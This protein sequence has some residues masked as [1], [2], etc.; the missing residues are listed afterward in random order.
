MLKN[1]TK[2]AGLCMLPVAAIVLLI[3]MLIPAPLQRDHPRALPWELPDYRLANTHWEI[4]ADGRIYTEVEHFFLRDISP[5]MIAWF[6]Q[7]LPISTL[8]YQGVTYPLYH[9]FHP[10]EH[11]T[12][13][14]LE[15]AP[16]GVSG[17]AT[18]AIIQR[19]EWFGPYDSRGA[20]QIVELS[21]AGMFAV[22]MA[23]SLKLGEVRHIFTPLDGGTQYRVKTVIGSELPVLGALVNWYLRNQV[24]HPK[25]LQQWQRHQIEEVASLQ[26]FLPQ[27]YAQRGA[28]THFV[29][30]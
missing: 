29:L 30:D 19:D 27:I 8:Q 10:T 28:G 5:E 14:V 21:P 9:I 16:S 15:A 6:Y 4:G 2:W 13:R 26:F 1:V 7:Q 23:G 24:F 25:M 18:G 22:P 20:A 3:W 11:G 17:M 12:I